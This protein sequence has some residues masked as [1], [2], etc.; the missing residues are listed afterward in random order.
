MVYD[1]VKG[2]EIQEGTLKNRYIRDSHRAEFFEEKLFTSY[3]TYATDVTKVGYN[4]RKIDRANVYNSGWDLDRY[5]QD[6]NYGDY[7]NGQID[8]AEDFVN[9]SKGGFFGGPRI[10][11]VNNQFGIRNDGTSGAGF[12]TRDGGTQGWYG[13]YITPIDK[14]A[15]K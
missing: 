7:W 12:N 11:K 4:N 2:K 9:G 10:D 8:A 6:S 5:Q 1:G 3:L 14:D 15:A 13:S